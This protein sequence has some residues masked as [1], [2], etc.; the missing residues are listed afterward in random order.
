MLNELLIGDCEVQSTFC[1]FDQGIQYMNF[2]DHDDLS[3]I[4]S[5]LE[6]VCS[7]PTKNHEIENTENYLS[8][9]NSLLSGE[10][11][12]SD[13]DSLLSGHSIS[14]KD[15]LMDEDPT[16]TPFIQEQPI[17]QSRSYDESDEESSSDIIPYD[18]VRH[19]D[20][21][22][23]R[24]KRAMHHTGNKY[25]QEVVSKLAKQYK[26]CSKVQK[27]ALSNSIVHTIHSHGGRFLIPISSDYSAWVRVNGLALRK[28]TSQALR[29]SM[30][31]KR[32]TKI[33]KKRKR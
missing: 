31:S 17:S 14:F 7:G 18:S 27:T 33:S 12:L 9:E 22:F 20:V 16:S 23:G 32:K 25:Y 19:Q 3:E 28:K 24:G 5:I 8:D 29:D 6:F 21:L 11:S 26:K 13:E 1:A 4:K 10:N 2:A 15:N 30:L